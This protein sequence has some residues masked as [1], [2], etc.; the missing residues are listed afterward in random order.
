MQVSP[1][2]WLIAFALACVAHVVAGS[3]IWVT[4][5]MQPE[6]SSQA[7]SGVMVSLDSLNA[8]SLAQPKVP[9]QAVAP[10]QASSAAPTP[11][12]TTAPATPVASAPA[13]IAPIK[14]KPVV[15]E[16][17]ASAQTSAAGAAPSTGGV[18]VPV[19]SAVTIEAADTLEALEKTAPIRTASAIKAPASQPGN[20][21]GGVSANPTVT[22]IARI[23]AWLG[24]HKYYP[25]AAR[26]KG[27]EG[28]VRLY[29]IVDRTGHVLNVAV[30]ESSGSPVLDQAAMDMVKRSE[31][32]PSMTDDMLRTRLEI[33]LPVQ[34]NLGEVPN[35]E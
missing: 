5:N 1:Q 22:Y 7:P 18:D 4:Q 8:G 19:A 21:A 30:A 28:V 31:P 12:A 6:P 33:I 13:P 14:P 35:D 11:A 26:T 25:H 16:P 24:N 20:G 2:Q 10:V 27:A 34:F 3:V 23:R 15:P 17:V 32:L 29:L 9:A